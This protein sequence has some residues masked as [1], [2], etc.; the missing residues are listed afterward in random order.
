MPVLP[1]KEM[2]VS[3]LKAEGRRQLQLQ[4]LRIFGSVSHRLI[5]KHYFLNNSNFNRGWK[6][7]ARR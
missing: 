3:S 1:Q 6:I 2:E 4:G 7:S 5:L